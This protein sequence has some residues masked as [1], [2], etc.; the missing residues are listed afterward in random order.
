MSMYW[1]QG[2]YDDCT[3]LILPLLAVTSKLLL[4]VLPGGEMQLL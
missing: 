2:M 3:V 4:L 1:P